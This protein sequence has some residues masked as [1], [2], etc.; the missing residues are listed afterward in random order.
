MQTPT[1]LSTDRL[2]IYLNDHLMGAT[3]GLELARRT[4]AANADSPFGPRLEGLA[5][6]IEEDRD[7]LLATITRLGY[8]VDRAK[9]AMGWTAEKLGRLKPNGQLSGYSPLSRLLEIESL[10][11]GIFGKRALWL[12]LA[13]ADEEPGRLDGRLARTDEQL[14][15][16]TELHAAA[17]PLALDE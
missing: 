16:L 9:V 5:R 12:A 15:V 8:R 1:A 13:T 14:R 3:I 7:E 4:A 2:E 10:M 17:A 6:E 11:G